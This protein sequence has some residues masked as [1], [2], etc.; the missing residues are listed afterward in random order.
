MKI[1]VVVVTSNRLNLLVKCLASLSLAVK[2]SADI[3]DFEFILVSNCSTDNCAGVIR[4]NLIGHD[5]RLITLDTHQNPGM[6]RNHA[7]AA[8]TGDWIF[9]ADDDIY[10]EP[11]FFNIFCKIKDDR[12]DYSVFGGPNR[13]P[14]GS[15]DFQILSGYALESGFACFYCSSRYKLT[16]ELPDVD[17]T[18]LTLCNLFIKKE[19]IQS[20][21]FSTNLMCAEENHLLAQ[22]AKSGHRFLAHPELKVYHERRPSFADFAK[23]LKKYGFGRGQLMLRGEAQWFHFIPLL[24]LL[25]LFAALVFQPATLMTLALLGAYLLGLSVSL[26]NISKEHNVPLK[27]IPY[28]AWLIIAV[29][30][31]YAIG[32][33]TGIV[34][35][36]TRTLKAEKQH[37]FL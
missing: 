4:E 8:A 3:A 10:I 5:H 20:R 26:A 30:F 6:A 17:D 18:A 7:L 33:G 24:S 13:T 32:L 19:V 14:P 28:M 9:F 2:N 11:D 21:R 34:F 36:L 1:S 35:E 12:K 25:F 31:Y 22:I 23:Q 16:K 29:H 27:K 37:D 15:T